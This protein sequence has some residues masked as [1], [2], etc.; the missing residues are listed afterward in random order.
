M[1]WEIRNMIEDIITQIIS[2]VTFLLYQNWNLSVVILSVKWKKTFSTKFSLEC[3][4]AQASISLERKSRLATWVIL[5]LEI[6]VTRVLKEEKLL[7][8]YIQGRSRVWVKEETK[9]SMIKC[10]IICININNYFQIILRR[11]FRKTDL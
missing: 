10:T 5:A 7:K 8:W 1:T 11:R 3:R 4:E 9:H 6:L 2:Y